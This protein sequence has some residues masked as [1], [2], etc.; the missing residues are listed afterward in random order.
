MFSR[1][2]ARRGVAFWL[3]LC[4]A[5]G[6]MPGKAALAGDTGSSRDVSGVLE[7]FTS[8]GC[9]SCP[10]ADR[11]L[12]EYARRPGIVTLAYHVDYWDYIGWRDPFGSAKN[13]QRQ[14][15]YAR[16]FGTSSVYTPQMVVNGRH[17]VVGSRRA[18]IEHAL[19]KNDVR[20]APRVELR[21]SNQSLRIR[22]DAPGSGATRPVLMLATFDTETRTPVERGEN[23]GLLLVNSHTVRDWRA[24]G[25]IGQ[26][27][28]DLEI[29]VAMLGDPNRRG[30]CA[31]F[32]QVF[33]SAGVP[34]PILAAAVLEFD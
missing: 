13:T 18:D 17:D 32:L 30:G 21:V 26:T 9:A 33:K 19:A 5:A 12:T 3:T 31:V 14:R 28:M 23:T 27:P 34:G 20:G 8:Q 6:A 25:S 10:P 16:F 11:L 22:A 1:T 15:G 29:P 2:T 4:A 24:L 7:L